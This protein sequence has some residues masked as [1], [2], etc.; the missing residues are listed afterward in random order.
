VRRPEIE[1][2]GRPSK[3]SAEVT[4]R[5][6]GE[7][8]AMLEKQVQPC[9]WRPNSYLRSALGDLL[10]ADPESIL[11]SNISEHCVGL[12]DLHIGEDCRVSF[13]RALGTFDD[14]DPFEGIC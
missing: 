6:A 11:I 4:V 14:E 3:N 1:V 7:L 13:A 5:P 9:L 8:Q 2:L 12:D 10:D